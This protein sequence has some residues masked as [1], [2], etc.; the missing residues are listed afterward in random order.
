MGDLS[1]SVHVRER[2][3]GIIAS[4]L[5]IPVEDVKEETG[6]GSA[7]GWDSLGHLDIVM[8]IED[9]FAIRFTTEEINSATNVRALY[10]AVIARMNDG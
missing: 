8:K 5:R 4:V 10:R 1:D 3:R 2:L 6:L 7:A 9:A